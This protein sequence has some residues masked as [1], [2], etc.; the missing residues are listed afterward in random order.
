M[1]ER[2]E[3]LNV[4]DLWTNEHVVTNAIR[5]ALVSMRVGNLL[6]DPTHGVESDSGAQRFLSHHI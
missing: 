5:H 1:H 4:A 6:I 3:A 2:D